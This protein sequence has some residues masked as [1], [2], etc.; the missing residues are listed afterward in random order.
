[1]V[2]D[3]ALV[4]QTVD[5]CCKKRLIHLQAAK[6]N[7]IRADMGQMLIQLSRHFGEKTTKVTKSKMRFEDLHFL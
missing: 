5:A 1:M 6:I 3:E 4:R 7:C 2:E